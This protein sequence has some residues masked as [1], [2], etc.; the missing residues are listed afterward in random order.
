[1][2]RS[3]PLDFEPREVCPR[4]ERP[5]RVCY[6]EHLTSVD[7]KTRIVLLQHPRE[8]DMAIGTARMASLCLPNSELHVGVDFRTSPA[9]QRALS[10]PDRPAALLYPSD[11][12]VDV[13]TD[14]PRGPITLVVVDGTWWQ[15]RKLVRVNPDI[16]KLPRYAFRAPT[17]SEYRIR[18][19]PDEAYVSTIEALVHVLGV[20]EGDPEKLRALLVP[21][22]AMI[23]K[24][25]A[26]ATTVRGARVRHNKGPAPP[27]RPR[28]PLALAE[29]RA[30]IVCV[31]GEANA[32][33]YRTK[34]LRTSHRE[35]LVHW[36]AHRPATG[37]TLDLIVRPRNP[38]APSTPP[39]VGL[40]AEALMS[41]VSLDELFERWRAFVRDDDV[42]CSWGHY[43]IGIFGSAGDSGGNGPAEPSGRAF[44]PKTRLDLRQ[45]SRVLMRGRVGTMD[46]VLEK[47]AL[48][49][50]STSS[51]GRGRAGVRAAQL[52]RIAAH[53]GDVLAAAL[54]DGARAPT[55]D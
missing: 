41:G 22:R 54:S 35:E 8:E 14:P 30:S 17:P 51:L 45:V 39:H 52:A 23:D 37:E 2:R 11:G 43:A 38:L 36:I 1:M 21:F 48:D 15:A 34:E 28:I 49:P 33:P 24:Q 46:A 9:L 50:A 16:A 26:F 42:V 53:L 18:K 25:I 27:K 6:C 47:L 19:E 40:S 32:W 29:R 31:T 13:L 3:L 55:P 5:A 4:C 20:L 12:A 10:D 7:T 44:M